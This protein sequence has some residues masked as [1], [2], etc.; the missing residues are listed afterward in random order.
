[1]LFL[2]DWTKAFNIKQHYQIHIKCLK[3]SKFH[4]LI[5][6]ILLCFYQLNWTY[7]IDYK[8][9]QKKLHTRSNTCNVERLSLKHTLYAINTCSFHV[10]LLKKRRNWALDLFETWL[11]FSIQLFFKQTMFKPI[12]SNAP[13]SNT[14][15]RKYQSLISKCSNIWLSSVNLK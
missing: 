10:V 9:V 13:A 4:S 11:I 14:M 2:G 12:S 6:I 15:L 1:M 5:F 8:Y 3:F 7:C